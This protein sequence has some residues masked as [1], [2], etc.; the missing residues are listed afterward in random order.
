[1]SRAWIFGARNTEQIDR[2]TQFIHWAAREQDLRTQR[3]RIFGL[4]A[5]E[6]RHIRI[7][8]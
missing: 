1:M 3:L 8:L 4:E 2:E 5:E 6:G 7:S